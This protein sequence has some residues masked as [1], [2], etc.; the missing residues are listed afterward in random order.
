MRR[1]PARRRGGRRLGALLALLLVVGVAGEDDEEADEDGDEV[2]EQVQRV[3]HE[4]LAARVRVLDDHLRA[5]WRGKGMGARHFG[6][7]SSA[8]G[9]ARSNPVAE[10]SLARQDLRVKDDVT[11]E[12]EKATI[13][14]NFE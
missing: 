14:L 4:V 13:E 3:R 1:R 6:P 11:H 2:D 12:H 9:V 10:R 5:G 8:I 7:C